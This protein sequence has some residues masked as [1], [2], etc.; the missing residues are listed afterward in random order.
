MASSKD[1]GGKGGSIM[2]FLPS[3]GP[4]FNGVSGFQLHLLAD[5]VGVGVGD[6]ALDHGRRWRSDA[7]HLPLL[8]TGVAIVLLGVVGSTLAESSA[9]LGGNGHVVRTTSQ[10]HLKAR[11]EHVCQKSSIV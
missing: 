1:E 11:M 2:Y 10:R 7:T 4:V 6:D 8:G 9:L 3:A 5:D